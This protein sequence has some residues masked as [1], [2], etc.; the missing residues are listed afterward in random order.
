MYMYMYHNTTNF[1]CYYHQAGQP[2][3]LNTQ[4][5]VYNIYMYFVWLII[6]G[7]HELQKYFYTNILD[8]KNWTQ[9]FLNHDTCISHMWVST[10]H[11]YMDLL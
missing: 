9:N 10:S 1:H 2:Q 6:M 8:A 7:W 11:M 3:K 5:F 4:I